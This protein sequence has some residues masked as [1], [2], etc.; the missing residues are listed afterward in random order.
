MTAEIIGS[1]SA[2]MPASLYL[3]IKLGHYA[4]SVV[5]EPVPTREP[6]E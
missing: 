4:A 6:L 5:N 1:E 2:E 3:P